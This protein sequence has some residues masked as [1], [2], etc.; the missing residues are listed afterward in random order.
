MEAD[1][2][3]QFLSS[4]TGRRLLEVLVINQPSPVSATTDANG[5]LG[6]I[7]G[8]QNCYR[9]LVSLTSVE[10]SRGAGGVVSTL[11]QAANELEEG[12]PS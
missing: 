10:Q 3:A 2:L 4:P 7:R 6:E 9:Q 11:Q 5:R 1:R 8:Y 12:L